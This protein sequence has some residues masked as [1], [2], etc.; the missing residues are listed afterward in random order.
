MTPNDI[1]VLI[2]YNCSPRLHPRFDAP[3]VKDAITGFIQDG[4]LENKGGSI[5]VSDRGR[6][7]LRMI[8]ATP[9]PTLA[10][11]DPEGNPV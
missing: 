7:W 6:A 11:V 1:D 5:E 2:H 3:A 9:Y 4:I 10:W 8:L